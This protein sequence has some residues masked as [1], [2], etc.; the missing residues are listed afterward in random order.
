MVVSTSPAVTW[1]ID[2]AT[3]LLLLK[4][5]LL[6]WGAAVIMVKRNME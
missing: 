3:H 2:E 5:L 4:G 6:A 1:F